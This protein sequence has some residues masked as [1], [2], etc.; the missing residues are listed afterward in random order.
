MSALKRCILPAAALAWVLAGE[1]GRGL[2][3]QPVGPRMPNTGLNSPLFQVNPAVLG[4]G[5]NLAQVSSTVPSG[6]QGLYGGGYASLQSNPFS[7]SSFL[8]PSTSAASQPSY[9]SNPYSSYYDPYG[10]YF[11]GVGDLTK[12]YGQ[13]AIDINNA[14]LLNQQVEQ[15]KIETRR[16]IFDEW[17]Y[18]RANMPN[19]EDVAQRRR[20]LDLRIARG[21]PQTTDVLSARSLNDL[22]AHLKAMH[23]KSHRGDDVS[24]KDVQDLLKK[25]NVKTDF[26]GN[27]GLLKNGGKLQWP[28]PLRAAAFDELRKAFELHAEDAVDRARVNGKAVDFALIKGLQTDLSGLHA[29]LERNVSS[30]T[31]GQYI[32]AKRYLNLLDDSLRALQDPN[33]ANYFNRKYEASGKTV[34][35]LVDNMRREGLTFAAATPGDEAAY[36]A[37]QSFLAA[38]DDSVTRLASR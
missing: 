1:P 25:I 9:P 12:A 13:Y 26:G 35:D 29:L 30:M 15:T 8:N 11:R 34:A 38:Y 24:L 31:T 6:G 17:R 28:V 3:A 19:A 32:D 21:Q 2:L 4:Y 36:R 27:I 10:G 33:V 23:G 18:E 20:E 16:R 37:L 14:R 5:Q 7:P 22:L